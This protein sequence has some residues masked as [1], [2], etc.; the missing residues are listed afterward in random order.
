MIRFKQLHSVPNGRMKALSDTAL[1]VKL[2]HGVMLDERSFL[3]VPYWAHFRTGGF[4][5]YEIKTG[6][7]K[8]MWV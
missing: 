8:S 2:K 5:I 3:D 7:R 1:Y 6:R 4:R